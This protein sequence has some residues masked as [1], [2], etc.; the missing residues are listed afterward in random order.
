MRSLVL[1]ALSST[2]VAASPYR[3]PVDGDVV[4]TAYFDNGGTQDWQCQGHTYGGHRG[5]DIAI[6]G[7]FE[8]QDQ[9]RNVV[10]AQGGRV[11]RTHDGEF[12]RC[13]TG[14]CAGGG[15]FGN[16]V[17]VQHPDGQISKYAHLRQGSVRV[18]D[19]QEV[20]CGTLLGQV[21]S[22]GSSTGPHLHFEVEAGGVRDD[23]FQG[24]CSGPLSYWVGQ[25]GYRDMPSRDCADTGP[26]PP[27]PP[28][29][30]R[31]DL[32]LALAV[33]NTAPRTCDFEDCRDFIR[34]G[35]SAG[36]FDAWVGEELSVTFVVTNQGNGATNAESPEDAAVT[37]EYALPAGLRPLRYRI[38]SD[39]PAYD[40]TSFA[41]N[42]AEA[43][44]ANPALDAP[45]AAGLLRLNGFSPG[46]SKR[47]TLIVAAT[48][49]TIDA[50]GH[51][52]LLLWVRHVRSYY[53][54]KEGFDDGVE[55]NEG[56]TFNG[57][58]LKQRFELDIF[59]PDHF[60]FDAPDAAMLEGWR[61]CAPE[62]VT[63][64][65]VDPNAHA[66]VAE[67]FSGGGCIES[68]LLP[69]SAGAYRGFRLSA[70]T[71]ATTGGLGLHFATDTLPEFD[72]SRASTVS[73]PALGGFAEVFQ[74]L[75]VPT[76]ER[77]LRVRIT[78][79]APVMNVAL[80]G[81]AASGQLRLGDLRL[82]SVAPEPAEDE[83]AVDDGD[84]DG[85]D[86]GL[87]EPDAGAFAYLDPTGSS[88]EVR[89]DGSC[90]AAKVGGGLSLPLTL[91]LL[92]PLFRRRRR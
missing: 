29:P 38:E 60:A 6:I 76:D 55:V 5:T 71:V 57:G 74:P 67:L 35:S 53:G 19:G 40:R 82:V 75:P 62:A 90:I 13:T 30:M 31:P 12:D 10:A 50:G 80:D 22:S 61:R 88:T 48:E 36:L 77:I 3:Q 56:Q 11:I 59:S 2:P 91:L 46:E 69:L 17:F 58:D 65:S 86:H 21:G 41:P 8:A 34:D 87:G 32:H 78:G 92:A 47:V 83:P 51:A 70:A 4:V 72:V 16:H 1:L 54:E 89:Y 79:P 37:V 14:D 66:L 7:R 68:P 45:P 24:P 26:P 63:A 9:G 73:L 85:D 44:P 52:A 25:G 27:P 64:L 84:G 18:S 43:N 42:D 20:G 15:G 23:P 28:P 81:M 39:H 33:D 49:R